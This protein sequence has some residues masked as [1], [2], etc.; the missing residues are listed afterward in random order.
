M[1]TEGQNSNNETF[2]KAKKGTYPLSMTEFGS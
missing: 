1:T 2:T